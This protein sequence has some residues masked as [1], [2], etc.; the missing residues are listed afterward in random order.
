M[1]NKIIFLIVAVL[2]LSPW[3][4]AYAYDTGTTPE[5][6]AHITAAPPAARPTWSTFRNAIGGVKTPGDLFYID[7]ADNPADLVATLYLT[8]T[9]ELTQRFRYMTLQVG[10]YSRR[11]DEPW[12]KITQ[13]DGEPLA[14]LYLTMLNGQVTFTLPGYNQHKI[15]IDGGCFYTQGGNGGDDL[16]PKFYLDVTPQTRDTN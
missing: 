4:V 10:I 13:P 2:L 12:Q 1:R 11:G 16:S 5:K 9:N 7:A 6:T 15:T 14:D 8:N 3:P